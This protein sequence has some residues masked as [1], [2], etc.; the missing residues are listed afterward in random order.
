MTVRI[1]VIG[2]SGHVGSF[3]VP[4]L[5]RVGHEVVNLSR[6]ARART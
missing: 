6:G 5:V 1:A 4:R 3:L 2:E